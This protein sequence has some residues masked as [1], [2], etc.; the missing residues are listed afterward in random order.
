MCG[1]AAIFAYH[2]DAPPVDR[3]QLSKIH[4]ALA[5]RGPDGE[6]K[7]IADDNRVAFAHRRLSIIDLSETGAQPMASADGALQIVFNGEIYNYRALRDQL[8]ADGAVFVSN[9]DTEVLLHL[10]A[11]KGPAMLGDLRGMFGFAIW[12]ERRK[13]M[14]LARDPYGIKP[15]Y[16]ADDGR[17]IR[18]A[19]QVKALL[20][21]G[22]I[23]TAPA[24]AGHTGF[25]LLGYVPEPYTLYR[26]IDS[27]P[28][29]GSLWID[30]SGRGEPRRWFNLTQELTEAAAAPFDQERLDEALRDS[31]RHHLIADVPVGLFLS[32]GLDSATLVALASEIQGASL[33]TVTLGFDE[34]LGSPDD[35]VPLAEEI[36]RAYGTQH[37]THRINAGDFRGNAESLFTAMDQPS[38]DG[39]NTY[40]VSKATHEA[41]L[42]VAISGLGG[43]EL[44][45]GYDNFRQI[46]KL[47]RG[48]SAFRLLPGLGRLLRW[49]SAPVVSQMISPKYAGLIEYGTHYGDA[50]LLRRAL[51]MPWELPDIMDPDLAREGLKELDVRTRLRATANPI[52]SPRAKLTALESAWYMQNQLLRD[53]DWAGMAHSL[54]IRVPLVDITLLRAIA[55]MINGSQPPGK[56]NMAASPA[57]PLPQAVLNRP[58][59]GFSVPVRDWLNAPDSAAQ[60][61]ST[62]DRGLRGW[63]GMVHDRL[64]QGETITR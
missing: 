30:S 61:T 46:P 31:V 48:L 37:S 7:W 27:L 35:E 64:W 4:D 22:N 53:S 2:P 28:A 40:F 62:Q 13:G 5:P 10:Y 12:D 29:G 59:T 52:D 44:F 49:A 17:T 45:G 9:S 18:V 57:Q 42:K 60:A 38:I 51:Y 58:K 33:R 11:R 23:D 21:G 56:A 43:D 55:P 32:S 16:F 6:G 47:V 1:I 34:Y 50:W 8:I 15:L 36:A 63:A 24:P 39:V 26:G 14:F 19:S 54:E 3:V 25:F 41:G 20:A